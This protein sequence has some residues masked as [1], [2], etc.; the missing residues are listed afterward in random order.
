MYL[1]LEG[2][3]F[4]RPFDMRR[5]ACFLFYHRVIDAQGEQHRLFT[6]PLLF[7]GRFH[8]LFN[9]ITG[10]RVFRQDEQ[11][12]LMHANGLVDPDPDALPDLQI[13]RGKPAAHAFLLEFSVQSFGK[14]L[15]LV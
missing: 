3:A 2:R 7:H 4:A 10:H 11:Q 14:V 12:L 6:L 13:F 9:P 5:P 15:I 8:L 1:F